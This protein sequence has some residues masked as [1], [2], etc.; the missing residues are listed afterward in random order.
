VRERTWPHLIKANSEPISY[1]VVDMEVRT[2][3]TGNGVITLE[4]SN[5]GGNNFY[6]KQQRTLGATGRWMQRVRWMGQGSARNRVFR[7]RCSDN[8]PFAI[9]SANVDTT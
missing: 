1:N 7:I 9:Y 2:G 3:V 4:V 5:D 8:A 6:P